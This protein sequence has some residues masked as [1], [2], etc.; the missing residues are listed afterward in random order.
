MNRLLWPLAL[1]VIAVLLAYGVGYLALISPLTEHSDSLQAAIHNASLATVALR[2]KLET[3]SAQDPAAE[4]RPVK[5][6]T[7]LLPTGREGSLMQ[8]VHDAAQRCNV[9]VETFR[10]DPAFH[11]KGSSSEMDSATPSGAAEPLPQLDENGSPI[12]SDDDD[13]N[14]QWPGVEVVPIRLTVKSTF[15]G[16]GKFLQDLDTTMPLFNVHSLALQIRPSGLAKAELVLVVPLGTAPS[17]GEPK[18]AGG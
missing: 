16:V 9:L 5:K 11:V 2:A 12:Q 17:P 18:R 6:A 13:E 15:K 4:K 7:T 8:V 3:L 1:T 14:M 10:L